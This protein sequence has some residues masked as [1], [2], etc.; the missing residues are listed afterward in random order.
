MGDC[1]VGLEAHLA[2]RRERVGHLCGGL[3]R[4][5]RKG[6]GTLQQDFKEHLRVERERRGV[7]G[8]RGAIGDERVRARDGMGDEQGDELLR[9]ES[10]VFHAGEDLVDVVLRL[11]DE[12]KC[13]GVCRI[14]AASKELEARGAWAVRDSDGSGKL[15]QV[16]SGDRERLK[17][18]AQKV[19]G[20]VDTV[21]GG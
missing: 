11:G 8:H 21:V 16:S 20:V 7:E 14:G 5:R 19:D 10:C 17:E 3:A 1:E 4:R 2:L 9:G 13:G 18:R 12:A 15:Y 6:S